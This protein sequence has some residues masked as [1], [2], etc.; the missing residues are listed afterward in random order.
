[1]SMRLEEFRIQ[2][3][4]IIE[5]TGWI[6]VNDVTALVGINESGKSS[7]LNALYKLNPSIPSSYNGLSEF[8]HDRYDQFPERGVGIPVASARFRIDPSL[9]ESL[10]EL[11]QAYFQ[12][13]IAECTRFYD[14]DLTINFIPS[15]EFEI[16]TADHVKRLLAE[17]RSSVLSTEVA[18]SAVQIPQQENSESEDETNVPTPSEIIEEFKLGLVKL[19]D[20]TVDSVQPDFKPAVLAERLRDFQQKMEVKGDGG[21]KSDIINQ[22][23]KP[24]QDIVDI[25][26]STSTLNDAYGLVEE[27]L[28][29]FIMFEDYST[30]RG[31]IYLREY[32]QQVGSD[33]PAEWVRTA[34]A[35]FKLAGYP[36]EKISKLYEQVFDT[37]SS[38]RQHNRN[39]LDDTQRE[40]LQEV[41]REATIRSE[42]SGL[43]ITEKFN[44]WWPLGDYD[45]KLNPTVDFFEVRVSD[46]RR[47]VSVELDYRS[48]GFKYFLSFF[49]V[50]E[51]ESDGG[52]KDSILLL[53]EPGLH[54][55]INAQRKL[56]Q[57]FDSISESNQLIYTTHLP[58]LIDGHRLDRVRAV[59]QRKEDGETIVTDYLGP[60]KDDD[61]FLPLQIILGYSLSQTL[62]MGKRS[63]LVEGW[64]DFW[65][66]KTL[67]R[68]LTANGEE[69]LHKD[70]YVIPTGGTNNMP[71][72]AQMIAGQDIPYIILLDSDKAGTDA[73]RKMQRELV[74]LS[75]QFIMLGDVTGVEDADLEKLFPEDYFIEA[76]IE[77]FQV[78]KFTVSDLPSVKHGGI[79]ESLKRYFSQ[80]GHEPFDKAKVYL[81]LVDRWNNQALDELPKDFVDH[82]RAIFA[83]INAQFEKMLN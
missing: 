22:F 70:T 30:L 65:T 16:L 54:L 17:I 81:T 3:Y 56:L 42:S 72:T 20:S 79:A 51:A 7:L 47:E 6:K 71:L 78:P 38:A 18:E 49:L 62:F 63:L 53:D 73:Q 39:A 14:G 15:P 74:G 46:K 4:R 33:R 50:F 26:N 44:R 11:H 67:D 60:L 41:T 40:R 10:I 25:H 9:K 43:R 23:S 5:D 76:T 32:L 2:N 57:F 21:W 37:A 83:E 29:I 31:N 1:M 75:D 35:L 34:K 66:I 80:Q 61:T 24:I 68:L 59:T 12:V 48:R 82:I 45:I 27:H 13:E 52:H 64:T 19:I 36:I 77:A 58:F 55:H 8:P 69:G 28:P